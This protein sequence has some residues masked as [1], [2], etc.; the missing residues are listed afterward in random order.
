V[1]GILDHESIPI[2]KNIFTH[3]LPKKVSLDLKGLLPIRREG[4]IFLREFEDKITF[5]DPSHFLD[6]PLL[7]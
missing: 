1:D 2:L 6:K 7:D 3:H 5:L 4:R